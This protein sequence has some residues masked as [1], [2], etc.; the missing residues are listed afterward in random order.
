MTA[1]KNDIKMDIINIISKIDDVDRLERIYKNIE[2]DDFESTPK[3]NI[4]D[5]IVEITEGLT[6]QQILEEQNYKPITYNE[7]RALADQI[8]WEHSLEEL[9][10]ELD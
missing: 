3:P 9:L 4:Q 2:R 5:A 10:A 6:Y 8:E 7:F 1:N